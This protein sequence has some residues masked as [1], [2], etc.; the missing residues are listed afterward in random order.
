A[1]LLLALPRRR[2]RFPDPDP[3][4]RRDRA[5]LRL[6]ARLPGAGH[7]R[8]DRVFVT[9]AT[10]SRHARPVRNQ[11][12]R[13][14]RRG[15]P[16]GQPPDDLGGPARA[17]RAVGVG[18]GAGPSYRR[19]RDPRPARRDP[20]VPVRL[21]G[22]GQRPRDDRR[23]SGTCGCANRG[24]DAT[25]VPFSPGDRLRLLLAE[26]EEVIASIPRPPVDWFAI[27]PTLALL[28]AAGVCLMRS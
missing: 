22:G 26:G 7:P 27:S 6:A 14:R 2:S 24:A 18:G 12:S 9:G 10:R 21:A 20:A 5:G 13:D 28:A 17:P 8:S 19:A 11:R 4:P 15:P 23:R 1:D 3:R 16:D 25:L